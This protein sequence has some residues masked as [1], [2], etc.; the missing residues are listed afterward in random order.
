METRR[1]RPSGDAALSQLVVAVAVGVIVGFIAAV[2][3]HPPSAAV[4]TIEQ[5]Q[6]QQQQQTT[7][8][9]TPLSLSE[10]NDLCSSRA[11]Q[12]PRNQRLELPAQ[13]PCE[14]PSCP[15]PSCPQTEK[16]KCAPCTQAVVATG[17]NGFPT[18]GTPQTDTQRALLDILQNIAP[19][20]K[21]VLVAVSDH[22]LI[23]HWTGQPGMLAL[24]V[25][26]VKRS[27]VKNYIVAA[28]DEELASWCRANDV[29]YYLRKTEMPSTQHGTGSNHATSA[30][31]FWILQDFVQL[32]YAPFLSDVDIVVLRNPFDYVKRDADVEGMSD[33]FD[34]TTA[35]GEIQG[36][37]D[38]TMGWSRYAQKIGHFVFNSG[39][40]YLRANKRTLD[41]LQM[42]EKK[43]AVMKAWDQSVFNEF[44]FLL[45]HGDRNGPLCSQRVLQIDLF[46]NSKRLFKTLRKRP[47]DM[48]VMIHVNYHPD[49]YERMV[50]IIKR[51]VDGDNR[52][53]DPFPGGSEPGS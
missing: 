12:Q 2:A 52:A 51:Y 14:C 7:T 29:N 35:Y 19:T 21:E 42:V 3:L 9:V 38:P 26:S 10:L 48:P 47:H 16:C 41:L 39:L 50:A 30:L 40:F 34:E 11:D 17:D 15:T 24:W 20:E 18:M 27:G 33:G 8:S 25:Q 53:L 31:K 43:L 32:G 4:P 44:L 36:H 23:K 1:G 46:V 6:Q 28:L 45:P 13:A 37:D 22:N 5:Q 49:K